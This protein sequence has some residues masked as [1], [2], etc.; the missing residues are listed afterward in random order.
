M[1]SYWVQHFGQLNKKVYTSIQDIPSES[2]WYEWLALDLII[3][4][5]YQWNICPTG[6]K[7]GKITLCLSLTMEIQT[8]LLGQLDCT[9]YHSID[10]HLTNF[11]TFFLFSF[12][13]SFFLSFFPSFF[14]S[15]FLS[16]PLF[17][18]SFINFFLS[19]KISKSQPLVH[20]TAS[21][22]PYAKA[23]SCSFHHLAI[24]VGKREAS[25]G[26]RP[27][28]FPC[29]L[30]NDNHDE[31]HFESFQ[32]RKQWTSVS[33]KTLLIKDYDEFLFES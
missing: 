27:L 32:F 7:F 3:L 19:R 6:R 28:S 15:F 10:A 13:L 22:Q 33:I 25:S 30:L 23:G 24:F 8:S 9:G 16:F 21:A 18:P 11:V 20:G 14:L 5:L 4:E 26:E 29:I 17:S 1:L 12:F 31:V 2:K